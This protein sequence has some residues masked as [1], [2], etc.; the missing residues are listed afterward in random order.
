MIRRGLSSARASLLVLVLLLGFRASAQENFR[1][2]F[3]TLADRVI[4]EFHVVAAGIRKV[5][6]DVRRPDTLPD[7]NVRMVGMLRFDMRPRDATAWH[8]VRCVFGYQDGRWRLLKAFPELSPEQR[9][10]AE[11]DAWY[12]AVVERVLQRDR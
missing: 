11:P 3:E 9:D 12:E 6:V 1:N 4:E 8:S 7:A 10:T 5:R 2:S